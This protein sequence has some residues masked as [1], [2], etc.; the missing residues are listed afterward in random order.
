MSVALSLGPQGGLHF[1]RV[2]PL[3][4]LELGL[5]LRPDVEERGL[6]FL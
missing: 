5:P 2:T 6:A 3:F 4:I 1:H